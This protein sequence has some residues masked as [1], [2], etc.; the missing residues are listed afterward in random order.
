LF[1]ATTIIASAMAYTI[2]QRLR[3]EQDALRDSS[4]RVEQLEGEL[5]KC[6]A[7]EN[8]GN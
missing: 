2:N 8:A 7:R 4:A 6:R 3:I 1:T 5:Q